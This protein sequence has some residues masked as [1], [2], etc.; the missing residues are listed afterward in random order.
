MHTYLRA[1]APWRDLEE[2]GRVVLLGN[3]GVDLGGLIV[4]SFQVPHRA[5]HTDTVGYIL[6]G[7]RAS[8][9]YLPDIDSWEAWETDVRDAVSAV[10]I[11]LL[12]ATFYADDEF[13]SRDPKEVP[14]P[15]VTDTMA[16]LDGLG[17]RVRLIH[18]NHTNPLLTDDTPARERGFQVAR[19]GER[20]D[21]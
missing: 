9:L 6:E 15:R 20:F 13:P 3:D 21:L 4:R 5:E 18:L 14:H 11:A 2:Q 10:D 7:P 19:E 1:N 8:L 12:D 17:E 16:R